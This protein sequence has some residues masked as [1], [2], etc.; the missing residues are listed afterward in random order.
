M[1]AGT[2]MT[3]EAD[4]YERHAV[5]LTDLFTRHVLDAAGDLSGALVLDVACGTGVVTRAAARHGARLILGVDLLDWMVGRAREHVEAE[6]PGNV[7]IARMDAARLAL[8]DAIADA[9]VCQFG[10]M[11]MGEADLAVRE[12][13][14][15]TRPGGTVVCAVWS[16]PD[17]TPAFA[18]FLDAVGEVV[19]GEPLSLEHAIFRLGSEGVLADLLAG[20]GLVEVEERRI[21]EVDTRA[22][23]ET[24][25]SGMASVAGFRAGRGEQAT[26][27]TADRLNPATQAAIRMLTLERVRGFQQPN[28][29]LAFPME[30]VVVR[31][32]VPRR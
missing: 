11:L 14:R 12:L 19:N 21:T 23:P 1:L 20:A 16:T 27:T 5:P 10:L 6:R 26:V 31:A 7:R 18:V 32:V 15:I 13:Q 24:Y 22:S 2:A 17:R 25:W 30:A 8:R 29:S 4:T 9:T 3:R 28:G